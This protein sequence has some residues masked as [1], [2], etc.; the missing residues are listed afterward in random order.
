[1][2]QTQR[3]GISATVVFM[4]V[5]FLI[6]GMWKATVTGRQQKHSFAR[7]G[8]S[9]SVVAALLTDAG[10]FGLRSANPAPASA[11]ENVH[12]TVHGEIFEFGCAVR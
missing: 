8:W 3:Q 5:D 12:S 4:I 6:W 7:L 9:H 11:W 2:S 1:V 10:L